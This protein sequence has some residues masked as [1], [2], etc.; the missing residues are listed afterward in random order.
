MPNSFNAADSAGNFYGGVTT[1]LGG[2]GDVVRDV[3]NVAT[4][5][6]V[7]QKIWMR[8]DG[9]I[10]VLVRCPPGTGG[11]AYQGN[12]QE[13]TCRARE[14][15]IISHADGGG[16]VASGQGAKTQ[17]GTSPPTEYNYFH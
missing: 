16:L 11:L 3:T 13:Y 1:N 5:Q 17:N 2:E 7:V 4:A 10:L 9:V 14:L 8:H 12:T 15:T 6:G